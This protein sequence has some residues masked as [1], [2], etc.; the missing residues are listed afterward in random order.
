MTWHDSRQGYKVRE[1]QEM[2]S[3]STF[4]GQ[5]LYHV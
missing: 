4:C 1:I 5:P 3:S 2:E